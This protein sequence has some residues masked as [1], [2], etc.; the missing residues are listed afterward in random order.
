MLVLVVVVV[1]AGLGEASNPYSECPQTLLRTHAT[2]EVALF[3][4]TVSE[5]GGAPQPKTVGSRQFFLHDFR[6]IPRP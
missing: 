3:S 1:R 2:I 6:C 5:H 4:E